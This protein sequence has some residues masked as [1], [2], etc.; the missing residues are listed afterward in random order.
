[1]YNNTCICV[2]CILQAQPCTVGIGYS[3]MCTLR[4]L[5]SMNSVLQMSITQAPRWYVRH[6]VE[7]GNRACALDGQKRE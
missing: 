2:Q 6:T 4:T 5:P 7:L 3:K 1:M